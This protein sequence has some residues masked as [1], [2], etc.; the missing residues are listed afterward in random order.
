ME[1]KTIEEEEGEPLTWDEYFALLKKALYSPGEIKLARH[2]FRSLRH[3]GT[4]SDFWLKYNSALTD[5]RKHRPNFLADE[6]N[7]MEDFRNKLKKSLRESVKMIPF[8]SLREMYETLARRETFSDDDE[9]IHQP[10]H[11]A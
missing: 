5:V 4:I 2:H 3:K 11:T 1:A 9:E 10:L 6:L 7:L 8:D